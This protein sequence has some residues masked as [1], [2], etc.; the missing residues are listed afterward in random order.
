MSCER[1]FTTYERLADPEIRVVKRNG[2]LEPFDREKLTHVVDRVTRGRGTAEADRRGLV[3]GLEAEL[4]DAGVTTVDSGALAE[5]LH[6]RLREL[7]AIAA[8]R[9]EM[10][11]MT[12]DGRVMMRAAEASTQL[13]LPLA[14]P[15][16]P[17]AR[18]SARKKS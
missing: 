3:R 7:D 6:A 11:Y 9:F 18:R 16:A 2:E 17:P 14:P 12:D 13:P 8:Q 15:A 10:N 4:V 1:R 5:R